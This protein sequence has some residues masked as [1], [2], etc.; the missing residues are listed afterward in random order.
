MRELAPPSVFEALD[1]NHRLRYWTAKLAD[2]DP[3]Q[4]VTIAEIGSKLVGIGAVGRPSDPIFG[5]RAE[6]KNLYVLPGYQ[7]QGIGTHILKDLAA[8]AKAAGYGSVTLSV[9][10]GNK[11]A[12]RFYEARR[13][14][15]IGEFRDPGPIWRSDN[16]VYGWDE[17]DQLMS[18][19][20]E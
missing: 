13:A 8:H 12:A 9:V 20:P 15:K 19:G 16:V 6:I 2:D 17:I 14:K 3:H 1:E 18:W 7:G 10:K 5:S 4:H 11:R